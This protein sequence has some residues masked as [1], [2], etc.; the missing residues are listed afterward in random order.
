M[1]VLLDEKNLIEF[2]EEPLFTK[3]SPFIGSKEDSEADKV[4]KQKGYT[5]VQRN[6]KKCKSLIVQKVSESHLEY[7]KDKATAFEAW[8]TLQTI[9][10]RKSI[11]NQIQLMKRLLCMKFN[12]SQDKLEAHLLRFDKAI[13]K[14]KTS[15]KIMEENKIICHLLLTMPKEYDAVVTALETICTEE[16]TLSF[17]KGRVI[18]EEAKRGTSKQKPMHEDQ[19]ISVF[20]CPVKRKVYK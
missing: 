20:C 19:P 1:E 5:E 3:L 16:L 18:D 13:R 12:P 15:G 14:L 9:F 6:A 8:E 10:E 7:I 11:T 4:M 17:V 2:V